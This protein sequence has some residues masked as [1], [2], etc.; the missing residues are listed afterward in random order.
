MILVIKSLDRCHENTDG[1][2]WVID[3]LGYTFTRGLPLEA[4]EDSDTD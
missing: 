3:G 4:R 1:L 2:G